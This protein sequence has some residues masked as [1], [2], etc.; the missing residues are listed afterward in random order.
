[1]QKE[2]LPRLRPTVMT[3]EEKREDHPTRSISKC[4][5]RKLVASKTAR[6]GPAVLKHKQSTTPP[7]LSCL[8][9]P[10]A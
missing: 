2:Q 3:L 1:M 9:L 7:A 8:A 5:Q 6:E 4:V 10:S